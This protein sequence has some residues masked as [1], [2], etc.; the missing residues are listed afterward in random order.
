MS[1]PNVVNS[2]ELV[3]RGRPQAYRRPVEASGLFIEV[4][5]EV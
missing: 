3:R 1:K 5:W 4:S 2:F